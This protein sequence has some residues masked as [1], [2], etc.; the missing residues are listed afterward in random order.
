MKEYNLT[1]D[2]WKKLQEDTQAQID[3]LSR[4]LALNE[5]ILVLCLKN[6]S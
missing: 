2:D 4:I 3:N 1:K 6:L 5:E